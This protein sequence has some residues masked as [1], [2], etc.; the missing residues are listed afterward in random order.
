M[1]AQ[2]TRPIEKIMTELSA[3]CNAF[4]SMI[5]ASIEGFDGHSTS[6]IDLKALF[7][8]LSGWLAALAVAGAPEKMLVGQWQGTRSQAG[9]GVTIL[10][11]MMLQNLS[12]ALGFPDESRCVEVFRSFGLDFAWQESA[13]AEDQARTV[14]LA[15]LLTKTAGMQPHPAV[16]AHT[17]THLC[18]DRDNRKF[19]GVNKHEDQTWFL[20]EGMTALA[21]AVALQAGV[22]QLRAGQGKEVDAISAAAAEHLR[23]RLARA[24]AVGYRLD[25]FLDLS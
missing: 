14:F 11:W 4:A 12:H 13:A 8:D 9:L 16:D 2:Q 22:M 5:G 1:T 20:Q 24:A 15:T 10:S 3:E 19:L 6:Q 23:Q 25:K 7:A 21:G 18:Q 17:F